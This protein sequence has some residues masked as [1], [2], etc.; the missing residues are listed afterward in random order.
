MIL[1]SRNV[2]WYSA[3]SGSRHSSLRL[4]LRMMRRFASERHL[5]RRSSRYITRERTSQ[6]MNSARRGNG[7]MTANA[8]TM[9]IH[10]IGTS[11]FLR[12]LLDCRDIF[13]FYFLPLPRANSL[14]ER[15]QR[16]DHFG[17][18]FESLAQG[19]PGLVSRRL[20]VDDAPFP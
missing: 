7:T 19:Q 6:K 12:N 17:P 4:V 11:S 9:P 13:A 18:F 10:S 15:Q 14:Q 3:L 8:S 5:P 20:Q 16:H 1:A 2:G